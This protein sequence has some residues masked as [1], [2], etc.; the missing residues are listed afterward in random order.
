MRRARRASL[1]ID[2]R[3]GRAGDEVAL[4]QIAAQLDQRVGLGLGLDA[5]ADHRHAMLAAQLRDRADQA[6]LQR[7]SVDVADQGHVELD[8]VSVERAN[9]AHPRVAS[10][11]VVDRDPEPA[12]AQLGDAVAYVTE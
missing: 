7:M 4:Q 2:E 12:L 10:S 8:E 6:L 5:L 9:G 3:W 1:R 11:K